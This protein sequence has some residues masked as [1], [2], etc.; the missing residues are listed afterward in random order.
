MTDYFLFSSRGEFR[1]WLQDN[2]LSSG[3][4]WLLF[5][6]S[7]G[8]KTVTA[9]EALEEALCFGWIDGQMQSIDDKAYIK[10]FSLRRKNSNWSDKN[11]A[12]VETLEKR[13]IMTDY[14]RAKITEAKNNGQWD[15]PNPLA[16][17]DEQMALLSELLKEHE[18][19]CTN[20]QAMSSSVK[21]TYARAYFDAK[22]DAGRAKRLSWMVERLNKNLKP[23]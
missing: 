14:G 16:V 10:Y 22:T 12:L 23:M 11:K 19:A 20:F 5:G 13:G 15:A 4:V 17:S 21:K 2:C 1:N 7:G 3:G 18:L 9:A 8:P 6:K